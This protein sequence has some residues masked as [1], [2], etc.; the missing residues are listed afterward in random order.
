MNAVNI[1]AAVI[2]NDICLYIKILIIKKYLLV[3]SN[4]VLVLLRHSELPLICL[5][6]EETIISHRDM[7]EF[8]DESTVDIGMIHEPN[9]ILIQ[10][11]LR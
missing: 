8:S 4:L 10:V 5:G 7:A 2:T 9:P 1:I 11:V 3:L 6:N